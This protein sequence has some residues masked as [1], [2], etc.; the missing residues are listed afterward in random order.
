MKTMTGWVGGTNLLLYK[1]NEKGYVL[2]DFMSRFL[3]IC[4][5]KKNH[6][7]WL[8]NKNS[9]IKFRIITNSFK[10]IEKKIG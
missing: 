9:I 4:K 1:N 10:K 6:L 2:K 7:L 5:L 3:K 8:K